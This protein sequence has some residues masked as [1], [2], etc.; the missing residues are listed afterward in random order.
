MYASM[1]GCAE[2]TTTELNPIELEYGVSE[3][4]DNM[5]AASHCCGL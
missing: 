2:M 3:E 1:F 5:G 4:T